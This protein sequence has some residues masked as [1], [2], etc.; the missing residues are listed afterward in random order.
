MRCQRL[1]LLSPNAGRG[2]E[3]RNFETDEPALK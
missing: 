2:S 3:N 1:N